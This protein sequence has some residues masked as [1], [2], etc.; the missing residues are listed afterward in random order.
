MGFGCSFSHSRKGRE[1]K[2]I[3]GGCSSPAKGPANAETWGEQREQRAAAAWEPGRGKM[4][5][6]GFGQPIWG[7]GVLSL[8]G[9]A[10]ISDRA[11][12]CPLV[13]FGPFGHICMKPSLKLFIVIICEISEL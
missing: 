3:P 9:P 7:K 8:N 2:G 10:Q 11:V 12:P 4:R 1:V 5:G 6:L 13:S